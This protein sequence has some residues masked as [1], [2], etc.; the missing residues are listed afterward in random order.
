[1]QRSPHRIK[2]DHKRQLAHASKVQRAKVQRTTIS[3]AMAQTIARQRNANSAMR[4]KVKLT[5][6]NKEGT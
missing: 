6:P 5:M 1:M 4:A 2:Q 3:L